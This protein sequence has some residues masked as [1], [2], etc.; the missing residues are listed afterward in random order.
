MSN[1]VFTTL[2]ITMATNKLASQPREVSRLIP[3]LIGARHNGGKVV[4]ATVANSD[5][6]GVEARLDAAHQ[7]TA[8]EAQP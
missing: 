8:Y 2:R 4:V 5:L 1:Q 7:V 3:G 6:V